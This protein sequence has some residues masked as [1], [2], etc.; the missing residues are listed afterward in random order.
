[1]IIHVTF[2]HHPI[3]GA[4]LFIHFSIFVNL[5]TIFYSNAKSDDSVSLGELRTGPSVQEQP[6]TANA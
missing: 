5:Y 6:N 1:M 2:P 3:R 4:V